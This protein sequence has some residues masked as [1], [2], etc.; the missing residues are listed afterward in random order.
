MT[1]PGRLI[2]DLERGIGQEIQRILADKPIPRFYL[3]GK[4]IGEPAGAL[5]AHA[6]PGALH[7]DG[8]RRADDRGARA[9]ACHP[10]RTYASGGMTQS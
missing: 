7:G 4:G 5:R 2:A 10:S 3:A 9:A 8:A 1:I 6:D